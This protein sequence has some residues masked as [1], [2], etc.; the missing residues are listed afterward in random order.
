[1]CEVPY[2]S[3]NDVGLGEMLVVLPLACVLVAHSWAPCLCVSQVSL[4]CV[5]GVGYAG[6]GETVI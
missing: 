6:R 1:M 5:D 4:F 3:R 2:H